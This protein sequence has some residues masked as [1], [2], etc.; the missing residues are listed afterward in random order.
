MNMSGDVCFP[1]AFLLIFETF[2][3]GAIFDIDWVISKTKA[4][5]RYGRKIARL[6]WGCFGLHVNIIILAVIFLG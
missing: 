5:Q 2:F 4:D 1:L 3:I 6:L